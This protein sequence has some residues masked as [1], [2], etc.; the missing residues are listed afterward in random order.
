[1]HKEHIS[2][3]NG[4]GLEHGPFRKLETWTDSTGTYTDTALYAVELYQGFDPNCSVFAASF[5]QWGKCNVV[6]SYD[7][8]ASWADIDRS[9]GP[10]IRTEYNS[11]ATFHWT[12]V[13]YYSQYQVCTMTETSGTVTSTLTRSFIFVANPTWQ[14]R[15]VGAMRFD[16]SSDTWVFTGTQYGWG[17]EGSAGGA[18]QI[19]PGT[20]SLD[21]TLLTNVYGRRFYGHSIMGAL[22]KTGD[23]V[24]IYRDT[25]AIGTSGGTAVN[26]NE[27]VWRTSLVE[28][29]YDRSNIAKYCTWTNSTTNLG[30]AGGVESE[31]PAALVMD[32]NDTAHIFTVMTTVTTFTDT[33]S[34]LH[35]LDQPQPGYN[36]LRYRTYNSGGTL[37]VYEDIHLL[38]TN[39]G[40]TASPW[41]YGYTGPNS[42]WW[43]HPCT[44]TY[45]ATVSGTGTASIG[46]A[47]PLE[48][49]DYT[50]TN[51]NGVNVLQVAIKDTSTFSSEIINDTNRYRDT[52]YDYT[53]SKGMASQLF[54]Y[55]GTLCCI[56]NVTCTSGFD[57]GYVFRTYL[58][59]RTSPGTWTNISLRDM[60]GFKIQNSYYSGRP[61]YPHARQL[62]STSIGVMINRLDNLTS[63]YC[64]GLSTL[65]YIGYGRGWYSEV[66]EI[67]TGSGAEEGYGF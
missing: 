54:T 43:G 23:A 40:G 31:Y 33:A 1:M 12:D 24:F 38:G 18:P 34:V 21:G 41:R 63:P 5:A 27:S 57:S 7:L 51:S 53:P 6:K 46:I 26:T 37:S 8:G 4:N 58:A 14:D 28:G 2:G 55:N 15:C 16:L 66:T 3:W 62:T 39:T 11:T 20:T 50:G 35:L 48:Y 56:Y 61:L 10:G 25:P 29:R 17:W 67:S 52:S 59:M 65:G 9:N 42:P 64:G 47:I 45:T 60:D 30:T 13:D 19:W 32:S 49:F 22:R 36:H 44:F